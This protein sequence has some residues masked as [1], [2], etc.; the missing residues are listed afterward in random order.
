MNLPH[1]ITSVLAVL[2]RAGC[3]ALLLAPVA[4]AATPAAPLQAREQ[5][6]TYGELAYRNYSAAYEAV[7]DLQKRVNAFLADPADDSDESLS[8]LRQAWLDTRFSH[9]QTEAFRFYEGPIDFARRE[10]GTQGP[11]G[12]INAWP[13]NEAYIDSV[14]GDPTAGIINDATIPITRATLIERNARDD[15]ADVT[16]GFHAIE[17]LLWGQDF[18]ADGPGNRS[19]RDFVGV[20]AAARRREGHAAPDPVLPPDARAALAARPES[21]ASAA[22]AGSIRLRRRAEIAAG[23]R[24]DIMSGPKD[25]HRAS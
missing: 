24:P 16:T 21:L 17:F 11:E 3:C 6:A 1:P 10:D 5:L 4:R 22:R 25:A 19:A 18:N 20:G 9:G 13:L 7:L 2:A 15:E 23:N 14:R 8:E 12:R